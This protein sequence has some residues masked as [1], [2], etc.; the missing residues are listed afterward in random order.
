MHP[1]VFKAAS[2]SKVRRRDASSEAAV[3][4]SWPG[5]KVRSMVLLDLPQKNGPFWGNH[6]RKFELLIH[7]AYA[8]I[9]AYATLPYMTGPF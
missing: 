7:V 9:C 5:A 6:D 8:H 4:N 1:P 3:H 2:A